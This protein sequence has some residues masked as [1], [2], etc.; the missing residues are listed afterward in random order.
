M[1]FIRSIRA[2]L[3]LWYAAW[4]VATIIV[5]GLV[6][7][8]VVKEI[9]ASNLDRTLRNEIKWVNEFI[10]PRAKKIKLKKS[11]ILELQNLKRQTPVQTDDSS[12]DDTPPED[13]EQ[14][15]AMW[16]QIYEHTLMS[17]RRHFIQVVDR[18]GELLYRSLSLRNQQLHYSEIPYGRVTL[19]TVTGEDKRELRMAATQ[20]DFV[21][22]YVAYPLE[23]LNEVLDNLFASFRIIAPMTLLI[24]IV[25]GWLLARQSLKPVDAV[26]RAARE[27][28]A[29]NLSRRLPSKNVDDEIGRLTEQ[30]NDMITRLQASFAQI[31]QFSADASHELRTPLTI[32]RGE[33][34]VALR[35]SRLPKPTHALLKSIHDELIRMSSIVDSLMTLVK[36]DSG[37][38]VFNFEA[39]RIDTMIKELF[40][41]AKLLAKSKDID[42]RLLHAEPLNIHGDATRLRQLFLNLIENAIKYTLPHGSVKLSLENQNGRAIFTVKDTGIGIQKKHHTK[43]FDRF[44]RVEGNAAGSATGSG[45]GLSIAK[46]VAE[47][48][49]GSIVIKSR[50]KRGST[51]IVSLP[52]SVPEP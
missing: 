2:K 22:I 11:A 41:D 46:W 51:F 44:F 1:N 8:L 5:S 37:R 28:T 47:A 50:E 15:D 3:T 25:G 9:L 38:L 35:N 18:N 16:N 4:S 39:V 7:Y 29:Q 40:E 12:E 14:I 13:I 45:L 19:A 34:E 52:L 31:Q 6:G 27:I 36:S 43:I 26:T 20:N 49:H 48:H 21:K 17:P 42:V 33:I 32:M 23:P 10:E 30:F 24:S